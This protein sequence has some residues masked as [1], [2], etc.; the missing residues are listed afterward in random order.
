VEVIRGRHIW[1]RRRIA[2]RVHAEGHQQRK[3]DE[4]SWRRSHLMTP[5]PEPLLAVMSGGRVAT[6]RYVTMVKRC[7]RFTCVQPT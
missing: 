5:I 1:Q 7:A 3:N 2:L 4:V 6:Q